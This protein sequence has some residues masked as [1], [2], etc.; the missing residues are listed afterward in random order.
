[1]ALKRINKVGHFAFLCLR[2]ER[3]NAS[4]RSEMPLASL[5]LDA[6][7]PPPRSRVILVG[8]TTITGASLGQLA[9]VL[10]V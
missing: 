7:P 1:M 9:I 3:A 4:S 6:A 8:S 10:L 5:E 2:Q